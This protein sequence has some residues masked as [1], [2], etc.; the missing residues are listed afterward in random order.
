MKKVILLSVILLAIFSSTTNAQYYKVNKLKYDSRLYTLEFGDPY[1]PALSGVCSWLIPGLGQVICGETGRGLAFFGGYAACGVV[2]M[3][4]TISAAVSG[5]NEN[6]YNYGSSGYI[7]TSAPNSG[8]GAMLL[9]LAGMAAV[10]IW[11]I[12]DAVKVAKVNNMY[13]RDL[14]K[15][16]SLNLELAPYVTQININNQ[17]STPV[18][19]TMRVKF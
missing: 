4:G 12:V 8:G 5:T 3:V 1:N 17:I 11:S 16:S 18:G 9:G 19:L 10:S 15:T 6:M 7:Y 14:K 2:F 13:I